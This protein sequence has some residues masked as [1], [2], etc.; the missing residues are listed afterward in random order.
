MNWLISVIT[1]QEKLKKEDIIMSLYNKHWPDLI[2]GSVKRPELEV[3]YCLD[4][5]QHIK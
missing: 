2:I 1:N 3:T 4:L 5:T